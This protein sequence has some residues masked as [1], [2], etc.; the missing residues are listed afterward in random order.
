MDQEQMLDVQYGLEEE[1]A[2]ELDQVLVVQQARE[3]EQEHTHKEQEVVV[4]LALE[5]RGRVCTRSAAQAAME[6]GSGVECGQGQGKHG[7]VS[8]FI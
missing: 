7:E 8:Q 1:Q 2:L 6:R 5:S 3:Q 4:Q